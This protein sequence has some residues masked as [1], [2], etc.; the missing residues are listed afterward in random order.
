MSSTAKPTAPGAPSHPTQPA[1]S[2]TTSAAAGGG[3]GGGTGSGS[4]NS[5]GNGGSGGAPGNDTA[6]GNK[7][8]PTVVTN[9][10]ISVAGFERAH[11]AAAQNPN[12]ALAGPDPMANSG[13]S[14]MSARTLWALGGALLVLGASLLYRRRPQ[15]RKQSRRG[16]SS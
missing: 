6:V 11:A 9:T 15:Q 3:A 2:K 13:F 5:A 7:P 8:I 1:T 4:D 16:T 10:P 14:I 12:S